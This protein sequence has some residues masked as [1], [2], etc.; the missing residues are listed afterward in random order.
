[1]KKESDRQGNA[2]NGVHFSH[3]SLMKGLRKYLAIYSKNNKNIQGREGLERFKCG[4]F[5]ITPVWC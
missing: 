4:C 1:M 2:D 3:D 5:S